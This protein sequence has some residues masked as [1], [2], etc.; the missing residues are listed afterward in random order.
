[1]LLLSC[2]NSK[3][4][5]ELAFYYYPDKNVYYN[6]SANIFYYSIDG[7]NTWDSI[8]NNNENELVTLGEKVEVISEKD[9]IYEDNPAHRKLYKG[10]LYDVIKNDTATLLAVNEVSE[11]KVIKKR[12]TVVTDTVEVKQKKGI[13]KF[14]DKI[15]G[16]RDKK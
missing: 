1:M 2:K 15:F 13:K 3:E 14:F 12:K 9:R 7:A 6:P 11:R 10:V 5:E 4:N 16:K 8:A